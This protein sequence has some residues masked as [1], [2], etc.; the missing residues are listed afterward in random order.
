MSD[1]V[2]PADSVSQMRRNVR[3]PSAGTAQKLVLNLLSTGAMVRTGKVYDNYMINVKPSN[4]KLRARCLR[5]LGALTGAPE[6]NCRPALDDADGD[7][8]RA[9]E[10]LHAAGFRHGEN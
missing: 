4:E 1:A 3:P 8:R 9:A 5:I 10:T 2:H 7:I 6:E